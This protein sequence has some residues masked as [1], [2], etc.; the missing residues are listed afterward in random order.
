MR[1]VGGSC[2]AVTAGLTDGTP[3]SL[4]VPKEFPRV[5]PLHT[6][7]VSLAVKV[8]VSWFQCRNRKNGRKKDCD[9]FSSTLHNNEQTEM[10][11]M[12]NNLINLPPLAACASTESQ[13]QCC[14]QTPQILQDT[15][16][17]ALKA[18]PSSVY[19]QHQHGFRAFLAPPSRLRDSSRSTG[20]NFKALIQSCIKVYNL[21]PGLQLKPN[22][23]PRKLPSGW[24][25]PEGAS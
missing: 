18:V 12:T 23:P 3:Q 2:S 13:N 10:E 19:Q 8:P 1:T 20:C 6:S 5:K 24:W 25:Q 14:T 7:L 4:R 21:L 15:Q 17:K 22:G 9:H 16:H 11:L